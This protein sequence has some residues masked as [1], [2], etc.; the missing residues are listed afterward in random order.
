MPLSPRAATPLTRQSLSPDRHIQAVDI[1]VVLDG[2][3]GQQLVLAR[4]AVGLDGAAVVGSQVE[5]LD[6][7]PRMEHQLERHVCS[8]GGTRAGRVAWTHGEGKDG[9]RREEIL[10]AVKGCWLVSSP[11]RVQGAKNSG[12]SIITL[13]ARQVQ[14]LVRVGPKTNGQGRADDQAAQAADTQKGMGC[15]SE[16][17]LAQDRSCRWTGRAWG[18]GRLVAPH[19]SQGAALAC[20]GQQRETSPPTY[21]ALSCC[22]PAPTCRA[23]C[24]REYERWCRQ[25]PRPP[26]LW[27]R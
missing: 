16:G 8:T 6:A 2:P 21:P 27:Q 11:H 19:G 15:S 4:Q 26:R 10:L 5:G 1:R 14:R 25:Q 12:G 24:S 18:D 9:R 13:L 17:V 20:S 22:P 3:K 7:G 23:L